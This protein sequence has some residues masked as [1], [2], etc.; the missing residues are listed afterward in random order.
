MKLKKF[1]NR[2]VPMGLLPR[3][4]NMETILRNLYEKYKGRPLEEVFQRLG[5]SEEQS[6]R[7]FDALDEEYGERMFAG[8]LEEAGPAVDE[9]AMA[10]ARAVQK[11]TNESEN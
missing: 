1:V 3:R 5:I 8:S 7:I 9:A 2:F 6:K 11:I 10:L 4:R